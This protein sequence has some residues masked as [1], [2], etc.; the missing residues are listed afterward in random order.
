MASAMIKIILLFEDDKDYRK[1]QHRE[2]TLSDSEYGT[3]TI[4]FEDPRYGNEV[5]VSKF[6]ER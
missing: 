2:Y 6:E 5:F 4:E 3:R 1:F